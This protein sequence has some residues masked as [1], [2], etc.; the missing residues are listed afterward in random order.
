MSLNLLSVN[1]ES[2]RQAMRHVSQGLR[3]INQR[4]SGEDAVSDISIASV[5]GMAQYERHQEQYRQ[6]V[7]HLRALQRMAK[8]RGGITDLTRKQP[9]LAQKMFRSVI[10]ASRLCLR[11]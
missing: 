11:A 4:L 9:Y 5:I 7:V 10:S 6:G 8:L 3:L 1:Q 2:H